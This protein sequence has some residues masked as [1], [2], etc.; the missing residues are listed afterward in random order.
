MTKPS[1]HSRIVSAVPHD[2]PRAGYVAR[3]YILVT[4]ECG[5]SFHGNPTMWFAVGALQRCHDCVPFGS[6]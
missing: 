6:R 2:V 4:M 1:S 5:H 3:E